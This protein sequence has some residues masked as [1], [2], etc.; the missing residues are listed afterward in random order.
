MNFDFLYNGTVAMIIDDLGRDHVI[1]LNLINYYIAEE[2]YTVKVEGMENYFTEYLPN[3]VHCY[4]S[5][6]NAPSFSEHLDP[7]DVKIICI[8]GIKT[9]KVRGKDVFLNEGESIFLPSNT[10]HQATNLY[11]S[12]I[13]SIGYERTVD[14]SENYRNL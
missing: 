6:K 13:L 4:V 1:E 9:L 5:P 8:K 10:P 2:K 14:L 11:D 3:T 12:I 7:M